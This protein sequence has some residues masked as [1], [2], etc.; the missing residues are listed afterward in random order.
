MREF[1]LNNQK[2]TTKNR[3]KKKREPID[4]RGFFKKVVR[5]WR[6]VVIVSLV[7]VILYQAYGFIGH[8]AFFKVD[9]INISGLERLSKDEVQQMASVKQ[10][11]DLLKLNISKIGEQLSKNPWIANVKVQR[12]LPDSVSISIVER[13]PVAIVSMGYLYYMDSNGDVF[14]PLQE[15]DNLDFPVVTGL[16]EDDFIKDPSGAKETLAGVLELLKDMRQSGSQ[17]LMSDISEI[18]YDK[19]YGYTMFTLS[20]GLPIRV[21]MDDFGNKIQRFCK[22]YNELQLQLSNLQY[23]DL[24]YADRIVINRG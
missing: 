12:N 7:A 8:R 2:R 14:K 24:D 3:F 17:V 20:N 16:S 4:F 1:S 21:G 22:I 23:V 9:K 18:H 10:G 6:F 13:K 19:G 11:D 15:G 5:L